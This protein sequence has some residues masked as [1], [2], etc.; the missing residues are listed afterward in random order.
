MK[1][2]VNTDENIEGRE[3]MVADV[4]AVVAT[5]LAQFAEHLTRV[6]VH[7]SDENAGKSG[8]RDK[9]CLIEARPS[10]Q[11]PVS[12]MHAGAS[13]DDACH[14]ALKKMRSLLESRFGKLHNVKGIASIRDNEN[15]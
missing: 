14:G 13:V 6:E 15:R 3:A 8:Q 10:H 12:V 4:E 2:Q 11:K 5:M 1:V 9:R 7:I